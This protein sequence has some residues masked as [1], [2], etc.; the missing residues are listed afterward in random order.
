MLEDILGKVLVTKL[1]TLNHK[2]KKPNIS[3]DSSFSYYY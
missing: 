2:V 1:S 3:S